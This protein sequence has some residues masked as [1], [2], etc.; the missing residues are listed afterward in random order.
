MCWFIKFHT[1]SARPC[2]A[3]GWNDAKS[4]YWNQCKLGA[5]MRAVLWTQSGG[6]QTECKIT[7]GD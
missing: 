1:I 6:Y 4:L 2:N 7:Q 3:R 5:V